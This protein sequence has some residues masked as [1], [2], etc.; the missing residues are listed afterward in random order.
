MFKGGVRGRY[1]LTDLLSYKMVENL[2][3]MTDQIQR[4]Q[5]LLVFVKGRFC[6]QYCSLTQRQNG[7]AIGIKLT[8]LMK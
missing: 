8:R 5:V 2:T 3:K 1:M 4:H 6:E 7:R